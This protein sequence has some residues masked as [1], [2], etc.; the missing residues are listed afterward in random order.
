MTTVDL[1]GGLVGLAFGVGLLLVLWALSSPVRAS[2]R[3]EPR[4]QRMISSAGIVG[5]TPS[6]FI[7][8]CLAAAVVVGVGALLVFAVPAAAF[9]LAV[10]AGLTPLV[11][12]RRRSARR[13]RA[14]RSAWPDAVDTLA[15]GVRAGMALPEAVADLVRRGPE[16]L[17]PAA[18]EFTREY[19]A[20]GTFDQALDCLQATCAD[21]VADRVAAALRVAWDVGGADLGV[22]LRSL[23]SMLRDESRKRGEIEARQSWSVSAAQLAVAAPWVTLALLSLRPEAAHAYATPGG[24][25]LLA[26][27]AGMSTV[28]YWLMTRI[29]RLPSDPRLVVTP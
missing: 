3:R 12:L 28:A 11:L 19:R 26:C 23:S 22:V 16:P 14:L 24:A 20:R 8:S 5:L 7:G 10:A 27:C 1:R 15:A 2:P 25:V 13:A 18:A 6:R 21:A 29:A 4:I 9:I 17:R